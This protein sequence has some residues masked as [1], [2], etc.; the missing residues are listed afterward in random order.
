MRQKST[1][2]ENDRLFSLES[3]EKMM[4]IYPKMQTLAFIKQFASVYHT[5]EKLPAPLDAMILN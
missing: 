5:E 1:L 4:V 3:T 2:T